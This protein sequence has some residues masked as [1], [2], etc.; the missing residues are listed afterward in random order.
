MSLTLTQ[1]W[2]FL[3][4]VAGIALA[5]AYGS[6]YF[7]QLKPCGLCY[8]QRYGFWTL[9]GVS[10]I[11]MP[12]GVRAR[13]LLWFAA[14]ILIGTS[15]IAFYQVTIEQ[16]LVEPSAACQSRQ[17]ATT[18]EEMREQIQAASV[19][20]CDEVQARFLGL[21]MAVYSAFISLFL[22]LIVIFLARQKEPQ[23]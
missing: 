10:F 14:A 5:I 6:E 3:I 20:K 2:I 11:S 4:T 12:L 22:G 16:G 18:L 8:Y 23:Q 15:L 1:K 7:F 21:S 13:P 19:A 9:L 17:R